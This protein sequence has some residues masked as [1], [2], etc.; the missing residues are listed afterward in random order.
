VSW[1]QI[2]CEEREALIDQHGRSYNGFADYTGIGVL[3]GCTDMDGGITGRPYVTT[4]W[5]YDDETPVLRDE[6]WPGS[7]RPC[8]HH[9]WVVEWSCE[10]PTRCADAVCPSNPAMRRWVE[11]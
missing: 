10:C 9:Q 5:G 1:K 7:D 8:E 2:S 4:T 3:S 6:R 11:C